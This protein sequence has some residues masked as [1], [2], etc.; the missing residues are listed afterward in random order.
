MNVQNRID[1]LE[2]MICPLPR[3]KCLVV[4]AGNN[5]IVVDGESFKKRKNES[6]EQ[7]FKRYKKLN[8]LNDNE[9]RLIFWFPAERPLSNPPPDM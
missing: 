8:G 5:K 1:K 4:I 2:K 6:Y 9:E 3:R 7:T